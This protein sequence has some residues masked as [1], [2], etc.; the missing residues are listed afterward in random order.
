MLVQNENKQTNK[1]FF[2]LQAMW[3][4]AVNQ[5]SKLLINVNW[6]D[7][8]VTPMWSL[9]YSMFHTLAVSYICHLV[10]FHCRSFTYLLCIHLNKYQISHRNI[11]LLTICMCESN[12]Y[13]EKLPLLPNLVK[14]L[15]IR[16]YQIL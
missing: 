6:G 14:T 9:S 10:K 11:V 1:M 13:T 5:S 4:C 16:Q 12:I 8:G 2:I 3:N 15:T 7:I